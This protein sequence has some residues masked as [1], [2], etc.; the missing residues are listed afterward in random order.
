MFHA[1]LI[2]FTSFEN[3]R[4]QTRYVNINPILTC[5]GESGF[6]AYTGKVKAWISLWGKMIFFPSPQITLQTAQWGY[7]DLHQKNC[8]LHKYPFVGLSGS[9]SNIGYCKDL[10]GLIFSTPLHLPLPYSTHFLP[11]FHP[12]SSCSF[13]CSTSKPAQTFPLALLTLEKLQTCN[14]L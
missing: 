8:S 2:L 12:P 7:L 6:T 3:L 4:L 5:A 1:A 14:T 11:L 13:G 10:L 9:G